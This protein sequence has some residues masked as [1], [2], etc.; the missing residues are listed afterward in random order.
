MR[1][2]AIF[3]IAA[4]TLGTMS[5]AFADDTSRSLQGN[6]QHGIGYHHSHHHMMVRHRHM[7]RH[8]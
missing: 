8:H 2:L 3:A 7:M 5:V 6:A 1:F 4:L